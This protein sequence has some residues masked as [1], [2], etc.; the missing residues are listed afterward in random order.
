MTYKQY[1]QKLYELPSG[2]S[3]N[4]ERREIAKEYALSKSKIKVGDLIY[5]DTGTVKVEEILINDSISK[6]ECI[7]Y[8][9]GKRINIKS[10]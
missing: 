4:A 6:P 10:I 2:P 8:G 3:F 1:K 5:C 7:Y 9:N